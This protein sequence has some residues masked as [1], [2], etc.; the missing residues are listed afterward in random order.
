MSKIINMVWTSLFHWFSL[1]GRTALI[2]SITHG[3]F[4]IAELL[5]KSGADIELYNSD[6]KSLIFQ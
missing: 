1:I 2:D 6:G 4:D 5:I 3:Y